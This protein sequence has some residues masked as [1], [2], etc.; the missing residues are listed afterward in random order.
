MPLT[1]LTTLAE[2]LLAQYG[3]LA[4]FC[5]FLLEGAMLLYF[6]PSESLVPGAIILLTNQSPIEII[7]VIGIAVIGATIGQTALFLL[8]KR[9]GRKYLLNHRWFRV[10]EERVEQFDQW[11][12]RWGTLS[13]TASNTLPFV[14]G[15][16]TV[17]AGFARMD[18]HYF[19]FVSALGTIIFES[20]L[21]LLTLSVLGVL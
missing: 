20:I 2:H 10:S 12:E 13:I 16:L 17:P 4:L 14:R 19:I 18:S 6:A 8:A 1:E 3:Y 21:A 11:F 5:I 9:G 15:M 7:F